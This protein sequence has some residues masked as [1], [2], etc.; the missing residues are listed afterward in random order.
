MI[1]FLAIAFL[2]GVLS[3]A[4]TCFLPLVPA[5]VTYMGGRAAADSNR[6]PVRQ[7][8]RVLSNAL[9]FVAGFTT[10]FVALGAAAGLIGAD[11][12][13]YK[14]ILAKVA[15]VALVV[16]GIALL[17]GMPWLMRERRFD[18]AHRL[19]RGPWASYVVGLA[20]AI[21]WTPC[22]SPVLTAILIKAADAGTAS[23]GALLL[24]AYSAGLGIPFLV[25][26]GLIGTFTRAV[27]RVRGALP[28]VNMVGAVLMIAMGVLVYTNRLTVLNSYFPV[29]TLPSL[30]ALSA[31]GPQGP[32]SPPPLAAP[33]K[34]GQS[35]PAFSLTDI[36]GRHVSLTDLRGK[37]V[38]IT[39]W[40]TWCIPCR[41]ELPAISSAYLAHRNEGFVVV[42]VNYGQE[43]PDTIRKFWSQFSLQ[44]PPFP[45]PDG[46]V[47]DA[48]GVGLKTTGLPVSVFLSRDGKVSSYYPFPLD[49]EF[50]RQHLKDIL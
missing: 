37:A 7:Q 3:C 17:G 16:M 19:P 28:A 4:S 12:Q 48:Y 29:F 26:A 30:E 50:L 8:L 40:A 6:T 21:G 14:P 39:F 49:A 9:L 38:L 10:A 35:A 27:A 31:P 44:P 47:S 43:A 32:V 22:I 41:E 42:A 25:A 15:G 2:A 5:Y 46:R 1:G 20:F 33:L 13:A 36:D 24:G 23:Q 34:P 11:L 18:I 45:D